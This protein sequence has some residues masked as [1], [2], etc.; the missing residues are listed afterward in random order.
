MA[1]ATA[2]S[3]FLPAAD[4]GPSSGLLSLGFGLIVRAIRRAR[5]T[6]EENRLITSL[7]EAG[8]RVAEDVLKATDLADLDRL[9]DEALE[10]GHVE[11]IADAA[12]V[13]MGGRVE[14][15]DIDAD[16]VAASVSDIVGS[17]ELVRRGTEYVCAISKAL[18]QF[19][20][21]ARLLDLPPAVVKSEAKAFV[22]LEFLS[23]PDVPPAVARR[24]LGGLRASVCYLVLAWGLLD[25]R[26]DTNAVERWLSQAL[27]ERWVNGLHDYLE[28]IASLPLGVPESVIPA[29]ERLDLQA[30]T[31]EAEAVQLR[32]KGLGESSDT[33]VSPVA[34]DQH[35]LID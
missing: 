23:R 15:G 16:D 29:H 6:P 27:G 7:R 9:I 2:A 18:Q 31:K 34:K 14:L 26:F 19:A 10:R 12:V 20:E 25:E 35:P 22:S 8:A 3:G 4:A 32:L 24:L 1:L 13:V 17:A 33:E 11:L 21:C 28:L 30:L 5:L